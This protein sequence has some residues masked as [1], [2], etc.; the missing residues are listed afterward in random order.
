MVTHTADT[1]SFSEDW[2]SNHISSW[3]RVLERVRPSRVLEIGCY[4]G[5]STSFI[6]ESCAGY[7]PLSLYC[8]DTWEGSVDLS[9]ERMRGVE[10]RFDENVDLAVRR[11]S[12]PVSVTKLKT[13]SQA[14]LATLI[15]GGS[16]PFD[17]IY[18]DGSHTAPDV[19][20]DAVLA[21]QIVRVGGVMIFD[22]YLWSMEPQ[23]YADPLN[24][25][26]LAIDTF[27]TVYARKVR[28]LPDFPNAQCY[29]EKIAS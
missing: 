17:V 6:I 29:I 16:E 2:F 12:T 13:P 25:P 4:E 22:D 1:Y 9:P 28:V 3:N 26:K 20:L 24:A 14:A 19:L 10:R 5:R 18:I 21:F 15:A 23:L 8:V 7:G 11:A 27:A